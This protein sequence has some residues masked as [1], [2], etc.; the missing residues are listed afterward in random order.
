MPCQQ[1][2]SQYHVSIHQVSRYSASRYHLSRYT[3]YK[4]VSRCSECAIHVNVGTV[5]SAGALSAVTCATRYP[6]SDTMCQQ[7]PSQ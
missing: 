3:I 2:P 4:Y 5:S 6:F 7:V 1:V